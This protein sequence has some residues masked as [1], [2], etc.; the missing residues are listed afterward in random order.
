MSKLY[1]KIMMAIYLAFDNMYFGKR[2]RIIVKMASEGYR[3]YTS[4]EKRKMAYYEML[5]REYSD[6][7]KIEFDLLHGN[8]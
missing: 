7:A 6:L 3:E 4:D 2:H 8:N 1:H 5:S